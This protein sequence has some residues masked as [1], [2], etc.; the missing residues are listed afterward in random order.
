[1]RAYVIFTSPSESEIYSSY[2][3]KP[4]ECRFVRSSDSRADVAMKFVGSFFRVGAASHGFGRARLEGPIKGMPRPSPLLRIFSPPNNDNFRATVTWSSNVRRT[5]WLLQ[6]PA[7]RP[8]R[9]LLDRSAGCH[10]CLAARR[11][12]ACWKNVAVELLTTCAFAELQPW[13]STLTSGPIL[14]SYARYSFIASCNLTSACPEA[15]QPRGSA[16]QTRVDPN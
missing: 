5:S 14:T 9:P 15:S 16:P 11:P 10:G 3:Q 2:R 4:R 6:T 12:E 7:Q 13:A 8:H 1:M